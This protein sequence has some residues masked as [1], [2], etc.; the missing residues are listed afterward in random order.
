MED[1]HVVE[2]QQPLGNCGAAETI[3][4]NSKEIQSTR[5]FTLGFR[6]KETEEV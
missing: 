4:R 3:L 6:K 2:K 5:K 1:S